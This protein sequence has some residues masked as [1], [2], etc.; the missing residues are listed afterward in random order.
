MRIPIS[1]RE[2]ASYIMVRRKGW[3]ISQIAHA[4]GRSTSVVWRRLKFNEILI[5]LCPVDMRKLPNH[6]RLLAAARIR[7]AISFF[8]PVWEK[9]IC[10]EGEEP[11]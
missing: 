2:S 6:I 4:F 7:K 1:G 8:L 9:W 5:H 11:P 10:G 3:A